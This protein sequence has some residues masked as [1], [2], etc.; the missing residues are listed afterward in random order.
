MKSFRHSPV[1][2]TPPPNSMPGVARS[3]AS[4]VSGAEDQA[5]PTPAKTSMPGGSAGR[6]GREVCAE[7]AAGQHRTPA[8]SEAEME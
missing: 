3:S 6:V 4:N 5:A 7:A 8:S 2:R 1:K